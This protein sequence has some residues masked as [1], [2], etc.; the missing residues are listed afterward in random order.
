MKGKSFLLAKRETEDGFKYDEY[1]DNIVP[2]DEKKNTS[3]A[4]NIPPET[5]REI[6]KFYQKGVPGRG[7]QSVISKFHLDTE[8]G[9]ND[10]NEVRRII[11]S[12]I[13]KAYTKKIKSHPRS[14]DSLLFARKTAN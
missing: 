10:S 13:N 1:I 14:G 11:E 8:Y 7:Y 9:I 3:K 4:D 5:I 2:S 12:P 6:K